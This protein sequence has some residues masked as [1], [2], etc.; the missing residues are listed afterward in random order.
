MK[1]GTLVQFAAYGSVMD[2]GYVSKYDE[3]PGFMWVEC[4]KMGPQ[5]VSKDSTMLEVISESR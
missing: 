3:D 1:L 5:R 2:T 4:V